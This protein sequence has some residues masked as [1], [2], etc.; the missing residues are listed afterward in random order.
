MCVWLR[1]KGKNPPKNPNKH[2][3][4]APFIVIQSHR[5]YVVKEGGA[6]KAMYRDLRPHGCQDAKKNTRKRNILRRVKNKKIP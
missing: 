5:S 6:K 2:E 1:K 3:A 4:R